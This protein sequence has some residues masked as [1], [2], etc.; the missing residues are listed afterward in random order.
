MAGFREYYWELKSLVGDFDSIKSEKKKK[1]NGSIEL[2][3]KKC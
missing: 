1:K 2:R 3:I